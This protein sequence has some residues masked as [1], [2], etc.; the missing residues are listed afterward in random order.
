[1]KWR[2]YQIKL[3]NDISMTRKDCRKTGSFFYAN[4]ICDMGFYQFEPDPQEEIVGTNDFI[5]L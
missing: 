2:D 4:E 5:S 3:N 1:M